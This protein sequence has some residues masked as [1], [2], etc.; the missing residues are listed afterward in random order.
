VNVDTVVYY[1]IKK[2][3]SVFIKIA[4]YRHGKQYQSII[5]FCF[6]TKHEEE[7]QSEENIKKKDV[8]FSIYLAVRK[9]STG[10]QYYLIIV[11]C[12]IILRYW[13]TVFTLS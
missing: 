10:L 9:T 12:T 8:K 11:D 13:P 2:A 1:R 6:E 5:Y 4:N 7:Q 3:L